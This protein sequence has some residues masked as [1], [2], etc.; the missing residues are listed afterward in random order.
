MVCCSVLLQQTLTNTA[1]SKAFLP[2]TPV[3]IISFLRVGTLS[4]AIPPSWDLTQCGNSAGS[5]EMF[6]QQLCQDHASQSCS[7][8]LHPLFSIKE[9]SI[10]FRSYSSYDLM[11]LCLMIFLLHL[12]QWKKWNLQVEFAGRYILFKAP[13]GVWLSHCEDVRRALFP[14]VMASP[15]VTTAVKSSIFIMTSAEIEAL[16]VHL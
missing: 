9:A 13:T 4:C 1:F 8:L 15:W 5:K 6:V 2:P 11:R 3:T 10:L 7:Q 14:K 12:Q 16:A